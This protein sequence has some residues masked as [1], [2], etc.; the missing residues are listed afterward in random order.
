MKCS[1]KL[2]WRTVWLALER[3]YKKNFDSFPPAA[4]AFSLPT[5]NFEL[6]PVDLN[7]LRSRR[8]QF[9]SKNTIFALKSRECTLSSVG[10]HS[11]IPTVDPFIHMFHVKFLALCRHSVSILFARERERRLAAYSLSKLTHSGGAW[12]SDSAH[13]FRSVFEWIL[14]DSFKNFFFQAFPS[15]C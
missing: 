6:P 7:L 15:L 10:L 3:V 11:M 5:T 13:V 1:L 9:F 2:D 8:G 14:L 12:K 4:F